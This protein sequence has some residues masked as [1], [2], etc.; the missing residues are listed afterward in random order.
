MSASDAAAWLALGLS[1]ISISWQ[2]VSFVKSGPKLR[3]RVGWDVGTAMDSSE[4]AYIVIV[5]N[6]GRQ[7]RAV[8]DVCLTYPIPQV[9]RSLHLR[10]K[11]TPAY[12]ASIISHSDGDQPVD[13]QPGGEV[14]FRYPAAGIDAMLGAMN[15]S[16]SDLIGWVRSGNKWIK[17]RSGIAETR[18]EG[19][20]LSN[21]DL[22]KG[23]SGD[24]GQPPTARR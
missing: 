19:V 7:A 15:A 24:V 8:R 22:G 2:V 20:P 3:V 4:F 1:A 5:T 21:Q 13:V 6:D 12:G 17:S 10:R 11:R 16:R 9:R 14:R 18:L 23:G